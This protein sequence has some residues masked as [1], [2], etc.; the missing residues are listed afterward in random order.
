MK[1]PAKPILRRRPI[2]MLT[3]LRKRSL[4][5]WKRVSLRID[6]Q[7]HGKTFLCDFYEASSAVGIRPF[8]MWGTLLGCVREG[9]FLPYDSDLDLGIL[10]SDYAKKE[11]LVAAM[12]KRGYS[13]AIDKAYKLKFGRPFCR[14]LID[15]DVVYPWNGK[16]ISCL[17]VEEGNFLATSF[18]QNAFDRLKEII[19]L[20]DLK[21]LIPDP[22]TTVLT[23]IY[24]AWRT[25]VRSYRSWKDPLNRLLIPPSEP[26]PRFPILAL[27]AETEVEKV[28]PLTKV[29]A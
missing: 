15:V 26:M 9:R 19:F 27:D 10:W 7:L 17:C 2:K 24:G 18:H 21:V 29:L 28:P 14:L 11:A 1:L 23:T 6:L 22:P 25:P 3:R 8:L 5:A 20:G 4:K 13:V 12:Q 16:M